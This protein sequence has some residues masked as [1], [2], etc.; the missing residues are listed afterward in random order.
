MCV[1]HR[2]SAQAVHRRSIIFLPSLERLRLY[3]LLVSQARLVIESGQRLDRGELQPGL[4][5]KGRR[6]LMQRSEET[7][8]GPG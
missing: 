6:V 8:T 7:G 3:N 4:R 1:F 2:S 5:A